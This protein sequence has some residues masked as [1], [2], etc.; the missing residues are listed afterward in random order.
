MT[1]VAALLAGPVFAE[2]VNYARLSYD[3]TN[4]SEGSDD[5]ALG[6]VQGSVEYETGQFLLSGE[7]TNN[8]FD[9]ELNLTTYALGAGYMITP[10]AL[11]GLGL[12]GA[13]SDASGA[14]GVNGFEGYAQYQTGQFGVAVNAAKF[15]SD[16]DNIVT[17]FYGEFEASPGITLGAV[18][19]TQSEVDGSGYTLSVDYEAGP[20]DARS[21][22]NGN[23]EAD[24][25][26]F[27]VRG[28]YDIT[29]Q[30][31]A[32]AAFATIVGDDNVDL[33]S[34]AIGGGY[35]I[36]DG[37]WVD[38]DYGQ[39]DAGTADNLDRIQVAFTYDMGE[40]K[41]IDRSFRQDAIDD[42][43]SGFSAIFPLF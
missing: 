42:A 27:G 9:G 23:S 13:E 24:A 17:T 28:T 38:A 25:G 8:N 36:T 11:V 1:A 10:E 34:F 39:V 29:P 26:T 21:F 3:Y 18:V 4:F 37:F 16:E 19:N 43:Q 41:R 7:L 14:D 40:Q 22:Y 33:S 30:F 31:R 5:L 15:D 35:M 12:T 32:S 20:I 6:V 2:G